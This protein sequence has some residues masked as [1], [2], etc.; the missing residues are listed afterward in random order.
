AR[1]LEVLIARVVKPARRRKSGWD[2][3]PKLSRQFTGQ[4]IA[5][6]ARAREAITGERYRLLKIEVAAWLETGDWAAP[7]DDLLR[8]RGALP[9]EVFAGEQL[10]LRRCKIRKRVKSFAKLDARRRHKLRIQAKKLRYATDFFGGLFTDKRS[11]KQRNKFL[12]A[13]E[14]VQDS[15]GDLNDIAVHETMISA[16]G[17]RRRRPGRDKAFAAGLLT[18]R[19]DARPAAV[20]P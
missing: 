15:L 17:M 10:S 5:A 18:G 3:I 7:Q 11:D 9:I 12:A 16:A 2:G 13:L 20:T 19:E 1:E 4:R 6:L 8:D 14:S